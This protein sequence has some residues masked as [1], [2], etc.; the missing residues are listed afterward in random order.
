MIII[1][2][3]AF[4]DEVTS[5]PTWQMINRICNKYGYKLDEYARVEVYKNG[6][7][8]LEDINIT[9]TNPDIQPDIELDV[10]NL[11]WEITP[12]DVTFG[13][14]IDE[15]ETYV[16]RLN[17]VIELFK[18]LKNVDWYDLYQYYLDE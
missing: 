10:N 6:N 1:K 11:K 16:E 15:Y 17:D 4:T 2:E 18:E 5:N 7:K 12:K 3:D 14:N 8:K 13:M 9:P